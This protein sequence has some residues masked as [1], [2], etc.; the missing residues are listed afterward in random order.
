MDTLDRIVNRSLRAFL[1]HINHE[2]WFGRENEAVSLYAFGFLQHERGE[3]SP[4]SDPTQIAIEVGV[5]DTPKSPNSQ[6]R[7][8]LVI[9]REPG[10]NRWY[11]EQPRSEPLAI[12]EWK[13]RR[14]GMRGGF[15]T[16][17]DVEWLSAHCAGKRETVGYSVLLDLTG[18]KASLKCSRITANGSRVVEF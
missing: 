17:P 18:E 6:V 5:A 14:P 7:K 1:D 15:S 4:L 12:M 13:V 11:P 9:W 16:D 10:V 2:K 8:D 3:G